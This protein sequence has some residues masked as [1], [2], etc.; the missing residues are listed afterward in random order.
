MSENLL[1]PA[2]IEALLGK[3]TPGLDSVSRT[4]AQEPESA[5]DAGRAKS[6]LEA[7]KRSNESVADRKRRN[8]LWAIH[9]Q[10]ARAAG[11]AL[12][13][14]LR[15]AV[16]VRLTGIDAIGCQSFA[17]DM[18][19]HTCICL[20]RS[21]AVSGQLILEMPATILVPMLDRMVGGGVSAITTA[22]PRALSEIEQR[23]AMRLANCIAG[24]LN[25]GWESSIDLAL[26]L[27]RVETD[28]RWLSLGPPEGEA[29][30]ASFDVRLGK[31][32]GILRF[33]I[34]PQAMDVLEGY[35]ATGHPTTLRGPH[36]AAF[37]RVQTPD[38]HAELTV[39]L[40]P[41]PTTA[42]DIANLNVGDVIATEHRIDAPV[43]VNLDGEPNFLG[44][45]GA[46]AGR[47]AV[48]IAEAPKQSE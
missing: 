26:S 14:L 8:R 23:L 25:R 21:P 2:E 4:D 16:D 37:D 24:E 7:V 10:A 40:S 27:D 30:V 13:A 34:P 3:L 12:S 18:E 48:R 9:E 20:L 38:H 6:N 19:T 41:S 1:T 45:L 17:A 5:G 36:H 35:L 39:E 42:E 11:V 43:I 31:A 46:T 29:V 28:P 22:T 32:R 44:R 33:G 15:A 47:K